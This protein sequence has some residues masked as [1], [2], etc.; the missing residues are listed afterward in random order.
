MVPFQGRRASPSLTVGSM[1]DTRNFFNVYASRVTTAGAVQDPAGFA[2][3]SSN[4][5]SGGLAAV[6]P[7]PGAQH[8]AVTYHFTNA[9]S[10]A[11]A[12]R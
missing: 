12:S 3:S 1:S 6:A 4:G 7:A 10:F 11:I 9:G 2:M 5:T 8:W